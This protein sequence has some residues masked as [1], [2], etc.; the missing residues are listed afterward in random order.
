MALSCSPKFKNSNP[1]PSEAELFGT[2]RPPFEQTLKSSNMQVFAQL[3]NSEMTMS[4]EHNTLILF[5]DSRA[6]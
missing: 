4:Q 5:A 3:I 6:P 1:K 2:L